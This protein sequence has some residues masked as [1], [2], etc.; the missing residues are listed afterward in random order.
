MFTHLDG[1]AIS[2]SQDQK[3]WRRLLELA[4]MPHRR[5]HTL[6]STA[7]TLPRRAQVDEA[8]RMELFGHT[9]V[10]VQ[11]LY[12]EPDLKQ[13]RGAMGKLAELLTRRISRASRTSAAPCR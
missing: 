5:Q 4:G 6:R 9:T 13:H 2:Q 11:H 12:A 10:K 8:T 3:A 7:A 1:S